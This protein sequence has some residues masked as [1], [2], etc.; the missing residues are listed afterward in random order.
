MEEVWGQ[1]KREEAPTDQGEG[2]EAV[3]GGQKEGGGCWWWPMVSRVS[4]GWVLMGG[5]Y[6]LENVA[7][8]TMIK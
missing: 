8:D 2:A 3:G 7:L 1:Q 5:G 6:G 4:G